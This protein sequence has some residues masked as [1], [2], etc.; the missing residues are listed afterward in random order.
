MKDNSYRSSTRIIAEA[1]TSLF[2]LR[3]LTAIPY[4]VAESKKHFLPLGTPAAYHF[5]LTSQLKR[6]EG[7]VGKSQM[8]QVVSRYQES[9]RL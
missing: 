9:I 8:K 1:L 7:G 2:A 3:S 4:N 5:V 6:T